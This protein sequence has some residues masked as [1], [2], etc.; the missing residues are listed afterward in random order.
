MVLARILRSTVTVAAILSYVPPNP[1]Q[2]VLHSGVNAW[3]VQ[4]C[5]A[6]PGHHES[7]DRLHHLHENATDQ[8]KRK[9]E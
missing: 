4:H 7:M 1:G 6:F 2:P 5:T 8:Q 9:V 3:L